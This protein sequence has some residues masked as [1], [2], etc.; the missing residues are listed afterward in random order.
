MIRFAIASALI[1][2]AA[3]AYAD[4]QRFPVPSFDRIALGGSPEVTVTTGRSIGVVATGSRRALDRQ[5][6]RVERGT[7]KIGNKH[8]DWSMFRGPADK[9]RIVVGVPMVRGVDVGGSGTVTVDRVKVPAFGA[10][11]GGSGSIRIVTLDTG[12]A[13]FSVGG[14][15]NIDAAGRCDS[16]SADIGGSGSLRLAGL[17]CATLNVSIAGS[18]NV[19]ANA[20]RTASISIAGSGDAR[21]AGGAHCSVSKA[22]SG[23]VT[24]PA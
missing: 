12:T 20:A 11:V 17:K 1:A 21:I 2:F 15:G 18:G 3:P 4:E 10:A 16:A 24:C 8:G 6:I 7:L 9:V 19:D 5:D 23:R 13:N 22:G 14:S